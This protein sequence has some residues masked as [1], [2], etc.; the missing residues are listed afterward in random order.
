MYVGA[1]VGVF[2]RELTRTKNGEAECTVLPLF[3]YVCASKCAGQ[4]VSVRA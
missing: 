1:S 3:R 2:G 4:L